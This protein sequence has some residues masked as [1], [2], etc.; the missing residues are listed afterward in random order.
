[1]YNYYDCV[2]AGCAHIY[3]QIIVTQCKDE[4]E[5]LNT[6]IHKREMLT[7]KVIHLKIFCNEANVYMQVHMKSHTV[8]IKHLNK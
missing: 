6:F 3:I 7:E 2:P 8:N 1:V 5:N 4:W